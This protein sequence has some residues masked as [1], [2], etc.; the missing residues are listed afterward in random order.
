W[1]EPRIPSGRRERFVY[2]RVG[3]RG[4]VPAVRRSRHESPSQGRPHRAYDDVP[5]GASLVIAV[6]KHEP[7]RIYTMAKNPSNNPPPNVNGRTMGTRRFSMN[8]R[9]NP[10]WF[11]AHITK[12]A[13]TQLVPNTRPSRR[14]F[15]RCDDML[16]H[17]ES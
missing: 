15:C 8:S 10:Q 14:R 7:S 9:W 16:P 1:G 13:A 4:N 11:A 3:S 17:S 5:V 6:R 12:K 2:S